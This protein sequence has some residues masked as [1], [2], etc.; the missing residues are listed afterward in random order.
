M[1]SRSRLTSSRVASFTSRSVRRTK[2]SL[3]TSRQAGPPRAGQT[4]AALVAHP[5]I[6]SR[7][8][9]TVPLETLIMKC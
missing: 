7:A 1:R 9:P 8:T 3:P 6:A 5:I 4:K 2:W